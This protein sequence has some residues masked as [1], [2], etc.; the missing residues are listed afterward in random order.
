MAS[1]TEDFPDRWQT[2]GDSF[3]RAGDPRFVQALGY[4]RLGTRAVGALLGSPSAV[5]EISWLAIGAPDERVCAA[6]ERA[7]RVDRRR[8]AGHGI[9]ARIGDTGTASAGLA[10][11]AALEKATPGERVVTLGFG[12]GADAAL[13]R[14]EPGVEALR[15]RRPLAREIEWKRPLEPYGRFLRARGF[16]AEPSVAPFSSPILYWREERQNLGL[17]ARRCRRCGTVEFPGGAIC[18]NCRARGEG[19]EFPLQRRGRVFTYTHDHLVPSP[20]PPTTMVVVDLDGGG[21]FYCQATDGS[22]EA[23]RIGLRGE[24]V[25]RKLHAG[26][27]FQNYFWKFRPLPPSAGEGESP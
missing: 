1:V 11:A 26:A 18:G 6:I 15:K 12:G 2:R 20:D 5:E 21:R 8:C 17:A 10:L 25:L 27:G 14:V 22:P 9:L 16:L 19:E 13:W 4:E 23:I 24:L 3:L 7:L